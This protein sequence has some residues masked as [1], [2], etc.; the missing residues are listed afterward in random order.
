MLLVVHLGD[1]RAAP[2]A[3]LAEVVVD[4][5]GPLVVGA[6]LAR[7][8][9]SG[10]LESIAADS[11]A[12]S[13]E[14]SCVE[15]AKGESCAAWR[16]RSTTLGRSPRSRAGRGAADG[17]AAS[18]RRGSRRAARR[19]AERLQAEMR[20]EPASA[21]A[22]VRSQTPARFFDPASVRTGCRPPSNTAEGRLL[23]T[24]AVPNSFSRP[25]VI[26]WT[27]TTKLAVLGREQ[28][29][30]ARRST[31]VNLRP[32]SVESGG[33]YVFRVAMW[34]GPAFAIAPPTRARRA[35]VA[36]SISGSSGTCSAHGRRAPGYSSAAAAR[37]VGASRPRRRGAGRA[38]S[39]AWDSSLVTYLRSA[40]KPLQALPLV[41]AVPGLEQRIALACA[42][43][44]RARS[45]STP[46]LALLRQARP[47]RTT[48]SAGS[49]ASRRRGSRNCSGKHAG[50]LLLARS[51]GWETAGYRLQR[52]PVQQAVLST[53]RPADGRP[54]GFPAV[55][56]CGVVTFATARADGPRVLA[57][58]R[59]STAA[60]R[61]SPRCVPIPTSSAG[62][63][64]PTRW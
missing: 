57:P 24:V 50:M 20:E 29:A 51:Q 19:Q 23:R 44:W 38:V 40:A 2:P 11:R 43:H 37:S 60:R 32:S 55:D 53:V 6:L 13:S 9:P 31:P 46:S 49:P 52:H 22:G 8:E 35:S 61:S 15:T 47:A 42:S 39:R 41:R 16:S 34:A 4:A 58:A 48:W 63:R 25:A 5:V 21:A 10:E 59:G 12:T 33:S 62:R 17:G 56:G 30:L 7:L 64:R 1:R 36:A 3:R 14:S 54:D 26:R 18:R 45:S 27:R 28:Q